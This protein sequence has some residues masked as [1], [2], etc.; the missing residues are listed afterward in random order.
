[1]KT[2]LSLGTNGIAS[3]H[4]YKPFSPL[5][6]PCRVGFKQVTAIDK[7]EEFLEVL[8]KEMDRFKPTKESFVKEFSLTDYNALVDGWDIKIERCLRGDQ[9]WALFRAVKE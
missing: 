2:A 4:G 3:R 9:G 7:T 1:M 6:A 8:R 5:F